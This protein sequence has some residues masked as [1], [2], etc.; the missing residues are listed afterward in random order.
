[1]I[2]QR[3]SLDWALQSSVNQLHICSI[4]LS[5]LLLFRSSG[6][7]PPYDLFQKILHQ[8]NL[9]ISG[10]S[11]SRLFLRIMERTV[12][13]QFIYPALQ[14]PPPTLSFVDQFAFRPTGSPTAA[15]ISFLNSVTKLLLTNPY[16]I[17]ISLDFSK[18]FDRVRHSTLMH[19]VA[20]LDIP[21]NAFNWMVDF[22]NG[23]SHCTVY[24]G[25]ASTFKDIT[26]SIIQGS[27]FGPAAYVINTGDLQP[28]IPG[29]SLCKFAD[30]TYLII[31]ASNWTS[32]QAEINNIQTWATANNLSLNCTKSSEIIFVD[33]RRKRHIDV[34]PLLSDIAR[35]DSLKIL[36]VTFSRNLSASEHIGNILKSCSQSMYALR[37]L[38]AHGMCEAAIQ[39][40]FRSVIIAKLTYA[41][42]AWRGFTKASD[43]QRIDALLRRSKRSGFYAT[44]LPMF[45]ELCDIADEQLFDKV[46]TNIFHILRSLLP[47]ESP[48]SQNYSLRPRVHNLQ[49]PDHVNHLADSNFF[50]RMLFKNV[51]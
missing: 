45:D 51:Y 29:N 25:T 10:R 13:T 17:V 36:G 2:H 30:D 8:R 41:A 46:Q 11:Q 15:I 49:L 42:S 31:P 35:V 37:L 24:S 23:H 27:S 6:S 9:Q 12:V 4:S 5:L 40:I 47:P 32:R 18:A 20:L 44:H 33:P 14:A 1:M 34:P 28:V 38:R 48:A 16:V 50:V 39:T 26:A 3:G 21:D 19:K 22:L 43:R 7:E